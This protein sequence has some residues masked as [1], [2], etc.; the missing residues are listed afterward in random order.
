MALLVVD[1]G[2]VQILELLLS[3]NFSS[4][5]TL[6]LYS[7]NH[8]PTASDTLADY[9]DATFPDYAPATPAFATPTL[10]SGKGKMVESPAID[11]VR[12]VGAGTE[13]IYGYYVYDS[14]AS[15]LLWAELA[16]APITIANVGDTITVTLSLTCDTE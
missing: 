15:I 12:G 2:K 14:S 6:G 8:T 1:E 10:V 5:V 9:T 4:D 16:A 13:D 7:N 11:F 3:G